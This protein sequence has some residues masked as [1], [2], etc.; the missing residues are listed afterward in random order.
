MPLAVIIAEYDPFHKGH[1]ALIKAVRD[2][3]ATHVAA[4]M[5][6]SFMQRGTAACLSKW[7]RTRL[8]LAGGVDMVAELPVAWAVSGAETFARGGVAL[9]AALGA[10]TL[11]FGSECGDIKAL[12]AVASVLL[13]PSMNKLLRQYMKSGI[14][15]AGAREQAVQ[16]LAGSA[17]AR[18]LRGPNNI[19]GIEYCK[20]IQKQHSAMDC[21]TVRRFGASHDSMEESLYPSA[22]RIRAEICS[23]GNWET[24]LPSSE[25]VR[26]VRKEIEAGRAPASLKQVE[27]AVLYRLRMMTDEE[28]RILPDLSEGL[29]NR[30]SAA[31]HM[32]ASLE[33][34]YNRLKTKRYSLARLRRLVLS[35]FLGLRAVDSIGLPPYLKILGFGPKGKDILVKA[36][37]KRMLP[38]LTH[39]SDRGKLDSTARNV[40]ELENRATDVWALCCPEPGPAG[41]DQTAGILTF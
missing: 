1:Q 18:L 19:L 13:Q 40:V 26:I 36:S 41:M 4:V 22:S 38:I 34:L 7:A 27:R 3:G 9:A 39:T 23:G 16:K 24:A 28:Y 11:A 32:A 25:S 14:S 6:G 2:A 21:F 20:A 8:A 37:Q 29:E 30:L 5:S 17:A 31:V 15:F 10:D 35:A 33:E 12:Q